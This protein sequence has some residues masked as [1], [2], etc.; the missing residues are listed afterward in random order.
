MEKVSLFSPVKA[1]WVFL[2]RN[3]V[4]LAEHLFCSDMVMA[5]QVWFP[6]LMSLLLEHS[7]S[8]RIMGLA[9]TIPSSDISSEAVRASASYVEFLL[10][11]LVE[12]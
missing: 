8:A 10:A 12:R 4:Y 3:K 1:F 9:D 6:D 7:F 2:R 11:Q 5:P